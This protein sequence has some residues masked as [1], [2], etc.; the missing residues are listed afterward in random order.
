MWST[1]TPPHDGVGLGR[2]SKFKYFGV[3]LSH[4]LG[5]SRRVNKIVWRASRQIGMIYKTFYLHSS[6]VTLLKFYF[7]WDP[8]QKDQ[9]Y[10]L[11][12]V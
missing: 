5:W 12:R 10:S 4:T 7:A 8:Y 11:E 9:I 3:W 2:V 6:Q 1:C